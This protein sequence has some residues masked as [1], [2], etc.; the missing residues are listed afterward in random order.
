MKRKKNVPKTKRVDTKSRLHPRSRHRSRYDFDVLTTTHAE[1]SEYVRPNKYGDLSI[2]F[3]DPKAVKALNTALLKNYYNIDQ[4]DVPEGYLCPPIPGRADHLHYAADLLAEDNGGTVPKGTG[5]K[6]FDVG[7]GAN[8]IYPIIGT[9]EY[10]WTFTGSDIDRDA[11]TSA[12]FTI[13]NN[14]RLQGMV[15]LRHQED[16][17]KILMGVVQPEDR[18]DLLICNPPFHSSAEEAAAV[19]IRKL[20]NLNEQKVFSA[21]LNFGGKSNELWCEGGEKWFITT[22]IKESKAMPN[23]IRWYTSL[24]SREASLAK[25]QAVLKELKPKRTKVIEMGQGNKKSRMVAWSWV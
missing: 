5:I 4:W 15:G 2:D 14:D 12:Q 13:D 18:Y 22:M 19:S 9:H 3:A 21:K 10:G 24:V 20:N 17:S 7:V 25:V 16:K 8:C 11:L 1:L 23:A 6:C